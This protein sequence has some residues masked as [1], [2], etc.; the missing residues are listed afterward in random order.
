MVDDDDW[1]WL[2]QWKWCAS[3]CTHTVYAVR[4]FKDENGKRFITG[5]HRF[6]L[7]LTDS[8]VFGEHE[9]GNGLNNQRSNIRPCTPAQNRMNTGC[10]PGSTSKFKGV[11]WN[12]RSGKWSCF[13]KINGEGIYIGRFENEIECARH[14]N[15]ASK[16]LFGDFAKFNDVLPL[17]PDH[18]MDK[19]VLKSSNTSGFRGIFFN[20][21]NGNWVSQIRDNGKKKHLGCFVD[22][23]CAAKAYDEK[24]KEIF[25]KS[26]LLNFP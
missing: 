15:L 16:E 2:S 12:K 18:K 5:M 11:S 4:S 1:E 7:G 9:D 20:K 24:A 10:M 13:I 8:K 26:A 3:V 14:Y 25:G 6:I 17:F 19:I 23:I 22:P 21:K